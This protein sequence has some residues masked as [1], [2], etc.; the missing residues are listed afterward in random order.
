M[1]SNSTSYAQAERT[2]KRREKSKNILFIVAL[3]IGL[4]CISSAAHGFFLDTNLRVY[5]NI[6]TRVVDDLQ[7]TASPAHAAIITKPSSLRHHHSAIR[8]RHNAHETMERDSLW[9]RLWA[10]GREGGGHIR[11]EWQRA[12]GPYSLPHAV[13][14]PWRG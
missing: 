4:S 12:C 1:P 6:M 7:S 9:Q 3:L 2:P 8:M 5:N 13:R 10:K 14:R 11:L